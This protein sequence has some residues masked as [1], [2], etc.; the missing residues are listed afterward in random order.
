[1][2]DLTRIRLH[3]FTLFVAL[4]LYVPLLAVFLKERGMTDWEVGV[5]GACITLVGFVTQVPFS[6]LADRRHIH[7]GLLVILS[8]FAG[9]LAPLFIVPDHFAG[10]VLVL[11]AFNVFFGSLIPLADSMT[12][13]II[14]SHPPASYGSVRVWGTLGYLLICIIGGL[15]TDYAGFRWLYTALALALFLTAWTA[16]VLPPVARPFDKLRFAHARE[17]LANRNMVVFL[18]CSFI[19]QGFFTSGVFYLGPLMMSYESGMTGIGL[20]WALAVLTELPM[21][22]WSGRLVSRWGLKSLIAL[23]IVLAA[24]RWSIMAATTN[25]VVI[26]LIQMLHGVTFGA[27]H[28]GA[29]SFMDRMT[30]LPA[31]AVGQ[32]IY[33]TFVMSGG[34]ILGLLAAAWLTGA[35]GQRAFFAISSLLTLLAGLCFLAWVREPK[36]TG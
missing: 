35:Y 17:I 10:L 15:L 13:G 5:L 32:S 19:V 22:A 26:V 9:C 6:I 30:P 23:G 34:R 4:G 8:F 29:V 33:A 36:P 11:I 16:H 2:R 12:F 7:R 18:L 28:A 14:K 24:L 31:R 25:I 21:M 3:V 27:L 1:M 20:A